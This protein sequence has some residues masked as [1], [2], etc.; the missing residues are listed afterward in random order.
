[1]TSAYAELAAR[2]PQAMADDA[3]RLARRLARARS[4]KA[5]AAELTRIEADFTRSLARRA[6][7]A[8]AK[9]AFAY[10]PEL[11][12]SQRADDI[13]RAIR[14]HPVVIVC[15]ETGS[16]K[17]TQLPKI[18][19]RAGRGER[20]M[21]GH[22]QPRRIAAR[23]VAARIAQ[24]LSE[25]V[26][27]TVGYKVRFTDHTKPSA[28][29][30]LM[31]DGILLAETQGDRDLTAY[32]TIIVDEAHERSLN[33]DFL[34][35]YL[36][37]LLARRPDL[38][39]IVT[40]ATL[41]ADRFAHHF[42]AAD[43]PAPVI[44]VSG[45]T[46]PV[47]VRYRPLAGDRA[48]GSED[49][50]READ[51]EEDVEEAVASAA[52]DL[53]RAGPGDIL[54]FLPGEREIRETGDLLRAALARRPY[55]R[56]VEILPLYARLSVAEQQRVF[57]PSKGRRIVLATN[58]AE[59][60]LTVP[61]IRSVIDTGLARVKRYSV[62]NKTTLLKIEKVSQAAAQ[63]RAGRS[64][65]VQDGVC[66]R[67]YAEGDFAK[68][69]RYTD[70]E[71]L[72]SSLASVI[73]RMASLDLGPVDAFPFLEPPPPRA[74]ADGYQLLQE[75]GAVDAE[76]ALTP[77]GRELARLPLDPRI[78]R[79]VLA[80]RELTCLP[81]ALVIASALAVPD[82]RERPLARAQAAD[83]A[84]LRFRDER[85]DFLSLVALWEFFAE[86]SA[87]KLSHRRV[88][89]A[90][91][92]QFV[93]FLRLLEW[94]DVHRQLVATL[95]E[96]G[97]SWRR[98]LPKQFDDA[99][100]ATLHKGLLAGLLG[101]I[102]VKAEGE[103]HYLGARGL[104]FWL[105][106]GSGLARVSAQ[107]QDRSQARTSPLRL[108]AEG[109][110]TG[111]KWILAAELTETTRLYARCAARIEPAWVEQVAGERVS[112]D[113]FDAHWEERRG[114]VAASERVQLFGLTLVA[115]RPVSLGP[116]D[117]VLA[118]EVF[119][120]EALVA[121]AL[122]TRGAFLAHNRDL[123]AE[124]A[125]LEHKARR[126]DVLVDDAAIAAFYAE[127]I[128]AGVHS[129]A[130][131]ER[132][133]EGAE[134]ATPRLLFLTRDEL[135]RHA[136]S[137]VTVELFPETMDLAGTTL[138]LAYRF[139][140]GH[141][142]DGLTLTVPLRLLNQVDDAR[143]SWLVPGMVREK[144]TH[145]LKAL[146]KALRGRVIPIPDAV[147]AFLESAAD[148]AQALP[149]ALRKHL[150]QRL[151]EAQ[152]STLFADV[153]LPAHLA[154][155]VTVVDDAGAEL[156]A[157]RD[158]AALRAQLGQ[159]A[160]LSFAAT[161]PAFERKG[162]E[163]WDFGDLP[164]S[165]A[166][167]RGGTRIKG[168]PALVDDGTSIS[169][170]LLDTAPAAEESTR[171]G[172]L[173]LLR[174]ALGDVLAGYSKGAPG[175]AEA[176]LRLKA[177]I[178]TDRLLADLREAA[179]VRAFLADDPLPRSEKAF[180]EQ[181]RRARTRLPA[182]MAGAFRLV[183]EIAEQH[184][185][186]GQRLA[187]TPKAWTRVSAEVR[188]ARDALVYPGFLRATPWEQLSHL[189][190]YLM[191][192]DRRLAKYAERAERDARHGEQVGQWWRRYR[193]RVDQDRAAGRADLRLEA[194]RWLLEELRVSLF[195]QELKTPYPVSLK[196]VERAWT[197]LMR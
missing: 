149:D 114:E 13:E 183:A 190:R 166:F 25:E 98:E 71:I 193:E 39:V 9:P 2:L 42:G 154:V 10:P 121:G 194:F 76:R 118:R 28:L 17:T 177:A 179:E 143:L 72:R 26:G 18:A 79:I 4:H 41:D 173:R 164:E 55:G 160:S 56:D 196:R 94:R 106:P 191:A 32:D 162:L 70:P 58:V 140:P 27:N 182:V 120:R 188:A 20:G 170:A 38:K 175:F 103:D 142:L 137:A 155:N 195:A 158:L 61:G 21:I 113:Y 85:S 168:Y 82:P 125:H 1:M 172:V 8:A 150:S 49:E 156:A 99:R 192:L 52:E 151:A 64:G 163:Q 51:D 77:L 92:A 141:P 132:W 146:P 131:F 130:S 53:W 181:V 90:C 46:Y 34:L 189:P 112:R 30:K 110:R 159:A 19:L 63:Q 59:T 33:I 187:S 89:D 138:P 133:R 43:R 104:R 15:G 157:G 74:I 97:W 128:P 78:G 147:T 84:H 180:A 115:R 124:V 35:G 171:A 126:Q 184:H 169:L 88:V 176:A 6:A 14:T 91:R 136:A 119:I 11:P 50:D 54:V 165:L 100:Y 186:L 69:S 107:A 36:K 81:E 60:S 153:G 185:A 134:R 109:S 37:Q 24:E 47:E 62:R 40:S 57:A 16:G 122:R 48:L 93:S 3:A 108:R 161:G 66:V 102:G 178:P 145:Y 95:E 152:P 12:V 148:P 96:A 135:M 5:P 123:V 111:G 23:A 127:R 68:R 45:R 174:I 22:T 44:E 197:E 101:N 139:S 144:V 31:T 105:H 167:D 29:I 116:V 80:A 67:L 86:L 117:P 73:L 75:L 129:A 7:R 87:Q 83:Q 65:R